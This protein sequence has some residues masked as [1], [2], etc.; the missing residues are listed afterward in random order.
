M[1]GTGIEFQENDIRLF[2]V[3]RLSN[4]PQILYLV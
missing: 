4:N 1:S 3:D 2:C